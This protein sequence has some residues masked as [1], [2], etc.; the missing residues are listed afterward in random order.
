MIKKLSV[1]I[2]WAILIALLALFFTNDFG[3]TDIRKT[4][5]IVAVG[6]DTQDGEVQ[7]TAQLAVPQPSESG[8]NIQYTQVQGSGLTVADALNEINSKTG[9]YP[10]LLFCKLILIGEECQKDELFKVLSCFYRRNYSELTALVAMCQ[11]RA[12][13]ML[14]MPATVNPETSSAIL[15]VLSD[16][17]E[18]SANVSY[19]NLKDI[20]ETNYSKSAACY[21]PYIEANKPGTSES[22]GGDSIGGDPA[23]GSGSGGS[24]GSSGGGSGESSGGGSG[25]SQSEGSG[26]GSS[27]TGGGQE[28]VEFTARR[29]AF[30]S[31]G[32]FA[33]I[34]DETQ[35]F[36]LDILKNSIRLAVLPFEVDGINYTLGMKNANGGIKLKVDKGVP[37]L[38]LS[39]K[40]KAQ[41]QGKRMTLDPHDVPFDD[42]VKQSVLEGAK[43]E[44][45]KRFSD[46]VK[47]CAETDCDLLGARN[48]LYKYNNKYFDAFNE[49]LLTRMEV[50]YEIDIQ[51]IN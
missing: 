8:N 31:N 35:A 7:V 39:F 44:I 50:K 32:K 36:A 40:A 46:L 6:V 15:Q 21:M 43:K 19:A 29:T 3:L 48:Q 23:G 13:D 41:I 2:Y 22:G 25:G 16:E 5:I 42:T 51:S 33:G 18:K 26:S 30:F 38:T 49:D 45:E 12:S 9:F 17:L 34:L 20:A 14:A 11:G 37:R 47:V 10:K 24:S 1:I 4:S 27:D 28:Q